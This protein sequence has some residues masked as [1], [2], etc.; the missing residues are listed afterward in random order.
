MF[1]ELFRRLFWKRCAAHDVPFKSD[2]CPHCVR[3]RFVAVEEQEG[4]PGIEISLAI[5]R[6]VQPRKRRPRRRVPS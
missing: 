3:E 2:M 4:Q 6:L 1:A 5:R